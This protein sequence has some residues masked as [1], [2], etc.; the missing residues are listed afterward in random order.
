MTIYASGS[1]KTKLVSLFHRIESK[2][3]ENMSYF[4][5]EQVKWLQ[6][7]GFEKNGGHDGFLMQNRKTWFS[8][9]VEPWTEGFMVEITYVNG[10]S[11]ETLNPD[12][13]KAIREA[14]RRHNAF[15]AGMAEMGKTIDTILAKTAGLKFNSKGNGDK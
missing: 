12:L 7:A 6:D 11:F 1:R 4:T 2:A 9:F 5:E 10:V 14:C 3:Q 8:M 15:L 13:K